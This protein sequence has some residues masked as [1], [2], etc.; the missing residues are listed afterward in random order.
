MDEPRR[1]LFP[2]ME[3]NPAKDAVKIIEMITKDLECYINLVDKAAAYFRKAAP[4]Q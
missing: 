2:E 3:S 4:F 1:T